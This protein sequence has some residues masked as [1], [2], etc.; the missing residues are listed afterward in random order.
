[1]MKMGGVA[2]ELLH[3]LA[4]Q[5]REAALFEGEPDIPP[6]WRPVQEKKDLTN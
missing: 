2:R 4:A 5:L 1:M 3:G 6:K